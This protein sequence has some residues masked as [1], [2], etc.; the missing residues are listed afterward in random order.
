VTTKSITPSQ[1]V[2][3]TFSPGSKLADTFTLQ[4]KI[5]SSETGV[6]W[7]ARDEE[8]EQDMMMHF[9]PDPLMFDPRA[10]DELRTEVRHNRQLIH[11]NVV[12]VYDLVEGPGWAAITAECHDAEALSSLQ[13]RKNGGIFEPTEIAPWVTSL[14]QTRTARI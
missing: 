10:L 5:S 14:C 9:L 13:E 12:R 11:P 6:L 3:E 2:A 7:L 8:M 1:S 4:Q